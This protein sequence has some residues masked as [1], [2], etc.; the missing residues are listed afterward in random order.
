MRANFRSRFDCC[1]TA[2]PWYHPLHYRKHTPQD[3]ACCRMML[4]DQCTFRTRWSRY[5]LHRNCESFYSVQTSNSRVSRESTSKPLSS[6]HGSPRVRWRYK[7]RQEIRS[8]FG[9]LAES[10]LFAGFVF[11]NR[12]CAC[13]WRKTRLVS[14]WTPFVSPFRV[15]AA[16]RFSSDSTGVDRRAWRWDTERTGGRSRS[17]MPEAAV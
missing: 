14:G 3:P 7:S 8:V 4:K 6:V 2:Y 15:P 17:R 5:L 11:E 13:H 12:G 10:Y 9:L 16:G 1:K